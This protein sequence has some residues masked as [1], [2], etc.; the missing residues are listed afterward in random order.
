MS[1]TGFISIPFKIDG[2]QTGGFKAVD[3]LAKI[4]RAGIVLEFEAKIFGIM[5]TGVKEVRVPV[6]EIEAVKIKKRF[7][8]LTLEIWLNNFKTLSEI[9]NKDGR[10]VLQI[11]KDDRER[12][13]K[14]AQLLEK[15]LLEQE[16]MDF[17]ESPVSRLF[18]DEDEAKKLKNE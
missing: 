9:P 10:I 12:A 1:N 11:Q 2:S 15:L 4:S 16:A 17:I 7:F 18:G 13:E 6:K 14:S 8:K 3:G 5:R